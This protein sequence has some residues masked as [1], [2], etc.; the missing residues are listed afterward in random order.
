MWPAALQWACILVTLAALDRGMPLL[1]SSLPSFV[2]T[3]LTASFFALMAVRSRLFSV[4]NNQRPTPLSERKEIAEGTRPSWMPPPIVFPFVWGTI[5]MLRTLSSTLI[6]RQAGA[7]LTPP[8]AALMLH[9]SIGDTWNTIQNVDRRRGTAASVVLLVL[10]SSIAAN[11]LYFAALPIAGW[12]LL[13]QTMWLS[14]ATVLVCD[15]WRLNGCEP[16]YPN[17][18]GYPSGLGDS[19]LSEVKAALKEDPSLARW[20]RQVAQLKTVYEEIGDDPFFFE[21]KTEL[22]FGATGRTPR[23]FDPDK[24][25]FWSYISLEDILE[26]DCD[27]LD[28]CKYVRPL[29]QSDDIFQDNNFFLGSYD[30]VWFMREMELT[31]RRL[32]NR[33]I[34]IDQR[35][36]RLERKIDSLPSS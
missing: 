11:R 12:I 29:E 4:L 2:P 32:E 34:D 16:L 30:L 18:D 14:V 15:I 3:A 1:P 23:E 13:P 36:D 19:V 33:L 21:G 8:I 22:Y 17:Y 27:T 9:L 25:A 5:A 7:F 24:S 20:K 26:H 28:G 35:L 6:W 10:A 31:S